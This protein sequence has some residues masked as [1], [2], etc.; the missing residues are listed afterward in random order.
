MI[1]FMSFASTSEKDKNRGK[2]Y[3]SAKFMIM[4]HGPKKNYYKKF[5][6]EPYPIESSLHLNLGNHLN[7][8]IVSKAI[9]SK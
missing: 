1:Q 7:S 8:S 6:F 4:C 9:Q 3:N 2:E 5:L